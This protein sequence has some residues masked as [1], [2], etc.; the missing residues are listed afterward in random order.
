[1]RGARPFGRGEIRG[2]HHVEAGERAGDE[3]QPQT[4]GRNALQHGVLLAVEDGRDLPGAEEYDGVDRRG[5]DQRRSE[6]IAQRGLH[7]SGVVQA[8]AAAD[9][10]LDALRDARINGDNDEREIGD[11]AVRRD[12]DV[13]RKAQ[14]DGVESDHHDAGGNLGDEGRDAAGQNAAKAPEFRPALCEVELVLFPDEVRGE[15][16]HADDRREAGG[17]N[18]AEDPHPAGE[19]EDPVQHDVGEAAAEHRGHR[20]LGR[21]VVAHEAE[22]HVVQQKGGGEQKD[23]LQVRPR[24]FKDVFIRAEQGDDRAGKE[25][26]HKHEKDGERGRKVQRACKG[27]VGRLVIRLAFLDRVLRSAAHA[28]HQ[29]AAADEAVNRNGKVQGGQAVGAEPFR[30]KEGVGQNVA[31]K[32][33]HAHYIEG[34]VFCEIPKAVCF[35]FNLQNFN[36]QNCGSALWCGSPPCIAV[37]GKPERLRLWAENSKK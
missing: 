11:D 12:A 20:K 14:D 28:D 16:Y 34:R 30:D 22:Q 36:L 31:G 26:A 3:V 10:R 21:A 33:D 35:H 37:P 25:K 27:A 17:E 18:G 5:E 32:P 29:A 24:H 7:A 6:R 19:D 4:F 13:A 8:V 9:D 15:N 1:M 2:N 23:H